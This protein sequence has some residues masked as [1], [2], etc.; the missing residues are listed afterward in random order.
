MRMHITRAADLG[1]AAR[2]LREDS[3]LTQR[4]LAHSMH[5]TQRW[6]SELESGKE[7]VGL[8]RTLRILESL[9]ATVTVEWESSRHDLLLERL[10]ES[11]A[12][13]SA[14]EGR[15]VPEG[16]RGSAQARRVLN[17]LRASA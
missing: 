16:Y 4:G 10:L 14:L 7:I 12:S 17:S 5:T 1:S 13:S 3:G 9:G 15:G 11:A 6:V 8:E 2:L